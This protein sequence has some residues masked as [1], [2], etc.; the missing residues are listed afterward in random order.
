MAK[1]DSAQHPAEIILPDDNSAA[2][3][4]LLDII[5]MRP[6]P[7][8]MP[9]EELCKLAV[10]VD[11]YQ[12]QDACRSQVTAWMKIEL[13]G[14]GLS[15]EL[16]EYLGLAVA[17]KGSEVLDA[18]SIGLALTTTSEP[19]GITA[20]L[21]TVNQTKL[22]YL[23]SQELLCR[24]HDLSKHYLQSIITGAVS[25]ARPVAERVHAAGVFECH[26]E[27]YFS[28]H[29]EQTIANY[30][31]A[32]S[33]QSLLDPGLSITPMRAM[34]LLCGAATLL[35]VIDSCSSLPRNGNPSCVS[36]QFVE[37]IDKSIHQVGLDVFG[38]VQKLCFGSSHLTA[39]ETCQQLPSE[40]DDEKHD[41]RAAL[42]LLFGNAL[43]KRF[44]ADSSGDTVEDHLELAKTKGLI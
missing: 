40:Q 12:C 28:K 25:L 27:Y 19:L 18:V 26:G 41:N 7:A 24:L 9:L 23:V 11:K 15:K 5:H 37:G 14:V 8:R 30:Y 42:G 16:P 36:C 31:C 29:D 4:T 13:N 34:L 32:L 39:R 6:L 44:L 3:K 10:L 17:F 38:G 1:L 43:H 2:L 33:S 22:A 35:K 20:L 21:K